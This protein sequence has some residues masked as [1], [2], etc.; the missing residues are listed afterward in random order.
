MAAAAGHTPLVG[1]DIF[2]PSRTIF[3]MPTTDNLVAAM[4]AEILRMQSLREAVANADPAIKAKA[5]D[6]FNDALSA[7]Y[8]LTDRNRALGGK[9]PLE[10]LTTE[11]GRWEVEAVL[12]RI[13]HGVYM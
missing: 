8:F 11:A 6:V 5:E 9:S 10:C 12:G 4:D 1:P 13:E 2:Q 7:A 3:T